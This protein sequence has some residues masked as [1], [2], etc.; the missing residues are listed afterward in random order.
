MQLNDNRKR[1]R[2]KSV[3]LCKVSQW[4]APGSRGRLSAEV[5]TRDPRAVSNSNIC[6]LFNV[7]FLVYL[8]KLP[9][10]ALSAVYAVILDETV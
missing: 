8:I 4:L 9:V 10:W 3:N 2:K 5:G 6:L 7:V 1:I